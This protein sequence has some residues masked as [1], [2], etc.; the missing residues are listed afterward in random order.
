[1]RS[2]ADRLAFARQEGAE[3]RPTKG[4]QARVKERGQP[5]TARAALTLPALRLRTFFLFDFGKVKRPAPAHGRLRR[6]TAAGWATAPPRQPLVRPPLLALSLSCRRLLPARSLSPS[7]STLQRRALEAMDPSRLGRNPILS[8]SS[9]C[10]PAA[11]RPSPAPGDEAGGP[12]L[13]E[14]AL[15]SPPPSTTDQPAFPFGPSAVAM[16][17]VD[18]SSLTPPTSY[19]KLSLATS[20]FPSPAPLLPFP[21]DDPTPAMLA[22]ARG[23]RGT[24]SAPSGAKLKYVR[25]SFSSRSVAA[26]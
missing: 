16:P 21:Q 20:A 6:E 18:Y 2:T 24:S 8:S 12:T 14:P 4:G 17:T 7:S 3:I 11:F 19:A 23:A 25:W 9:S 1:M 5:A 26:C 22:P 10:R 15:S 13:C